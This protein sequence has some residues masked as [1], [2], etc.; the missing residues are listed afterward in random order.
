MAGPAPDPAYVL[1]VIRQETEFD[2]DSV[3]R[4]GARGLMQL[5]PASARIDA[6]RGGL[7]WRPNDLSSDRNYNIQLVMIEFQHYGADWDRPL[8]LA[9]ASANAAPNHVRKW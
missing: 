2:P 3:S 8:V 6:T 9:I 4:S 5:M 7:A 1:G